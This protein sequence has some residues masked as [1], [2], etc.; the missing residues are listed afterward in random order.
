MGSTYPAHDG[1][2]PLPTD[3]P[4]PSY[5]PILP[6]SFVSAFHL[7]YCVLCPLCVAVWCLERYVPSC[8]LLLSHSLSLSLS[9]CVILSLGLFPFLLSLPLFPVHSK[10]SVNVC[11]V[12]I[13]AAGRGTKRYDQCVRCVCAR[14]QRL[15]HSSSG[16]GAPP[17]NFGY[18]THAA[19]WPIANEYPY[20]RAFGLTPLPRRTP[21]VALLLWLPSRPGHPSTFKSAGQ[22]RAAHRIRTL[23]YNSV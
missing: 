12:C 1:L 23:P 10:L 17:H 14:A 5:F 18:I 9:V 6:S 4:L 15:P 20:P 16:P 21:S 2:A 11:V 3:A 19:G 7:F 22:G 13:C 8:S